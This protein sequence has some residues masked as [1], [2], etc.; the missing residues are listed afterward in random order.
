MTSP[1]SY[2]NP[3]ISKA[4]VNLVVLET[5]IFLLLRDAPFPFSAWNNSFLTGSKITPKSTLPLKRC[6]IEILKCGKEWKK[7]VVPSSGS[8]THRCSE[9]VFLA[10]PSSV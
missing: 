3:E 10:R 5:T 4:S 2:A 8:M 1:R 9:T 7:L 6:A